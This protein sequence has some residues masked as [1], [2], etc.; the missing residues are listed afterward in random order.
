MNPLRQLAL[1]VAS[2]VVRL[3]SP[4]AEEWAKATSREIEFIESDWAALR[5]ALGGMRI[6]LRPSEARISSLADIPQSA[7]R[8]LREIRK[9]TIVGSAVCIIE[10][11]WIGSTI[12]TLRNPTQRLGCYLLIAAMLF[13]TVQLFARRGALRSTCASPA[14]PTAYRLELERQR[15]F[16]RGGWLWSRVICMPPGFLLFCLGAAIA[17]PANSRG[18]ATMATVFLMICVL[19]I[20]NNLRVAHKYQRRID[21]LDAIERSEV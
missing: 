13:L 1:K 6:L 14:I 4:G 10:T 12:H 2:G 7:S 18:P 8:F 5:W 21:D 9:R 19:A 11:I 3:A 20:P 16:H 15:D 17:H